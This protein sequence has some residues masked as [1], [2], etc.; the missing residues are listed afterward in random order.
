MLFEGNKSLIITYAIA[1]G[2]CGVLVFVIMNFNSWF[3]PN[4]QLNLNVYTPSSR[5]MISEKDLKF[6]LL[7]DKK[8][9]SLEPILAKGEL[10]E[11]GNNTGGGG[12]VS[13][14]VTPSAKPKIELRRSSPFDPF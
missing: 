11:A 1:L 12:T 2:V 14:T 8:F 5:G 4:K 3:F 7:N 9:T 10:A 13:G 6:G